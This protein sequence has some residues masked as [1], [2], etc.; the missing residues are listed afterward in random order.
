MH[1]FDNLKCY[2]KM[3][4]W[5]HDSIP[6]AF[7]QA[8]NTASGTWAK[9]EIF[10]GELDLMLLDAQGEIKSSSRHNPQQQAPLI[11]PQ[12]WHKIGNFSADLECQLSFYCQAANYYQKKYQL[13]ATHSEVLALSEYINAGTALDFGCGRGRN[14]LYLQSLG[15]EVEAF[16]ANANAIATL[17]QIINAEN[18]HN[19][20]A[21]VG[22]AHHIELEQKYDLIIST[23]VLMFLEREQIKNVLQKMQDST[24][25]G[26][27][28]LIVC[29]MDT[30]AHPLSE[31]RLAFDFGF[32]EGE[33]AAYYKNWQ[34]LKYNEDV[35]HLHKRDHNGNRI[36]LNFATMIAQKS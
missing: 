16:D 12:A 7:C 6:Q 21:W 25:P 5:Q 19:I 11:A 20:R 8:H 26:G 13:T 24:K 9:L 27:I 4:L 15:F 18:L 14:A 33:L 3:P 34:L 10:R 36:A 35:G 28:N 23:V 22:D 32:K 17:K 30:T 29:A 2:K 31:H 1:Q